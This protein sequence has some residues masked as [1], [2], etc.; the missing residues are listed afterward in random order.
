MVHLGLGLNY[1][2]AGGFESARF[3]IQAETHIGG[4]NIID[5]GTI[6]NVTGF[7]KV[8]LEVASVM[9]HSQHRGNTL[10]HQSVVTM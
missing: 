7:T 6:T 8:G 9:G 1:R 10:W 2:D 4:V 3:K 5:T